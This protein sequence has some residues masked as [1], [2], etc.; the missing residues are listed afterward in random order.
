M[1]APAGRRSR[2]IDHAVNEMAPTAGVPADFDRKTDECGL[3][4]LGL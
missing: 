4:V 2:F 3:A 1:A